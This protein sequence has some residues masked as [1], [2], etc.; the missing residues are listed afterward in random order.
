MKIAAND[1]EIGKTE[2]WRLMRDDWKVPEPKLI[3]S[4]TGFANELGGGNADASEN[5]KK[6]LMKAANDAGKMKCFF[7][8]KML[9]L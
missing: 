4:V 8:F 9:F 3:I 7:S 2:A 5:F 1:L 6:S